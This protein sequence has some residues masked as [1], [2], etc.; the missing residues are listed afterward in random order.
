M[1]KSVKAVL[2]VM[3]GGALIGIGAAIGSA[4]QP[5]AKAASPV[6]AVTVTQSVPGPEV[7]VTE[8]VAPAPPPA[9]SVIGTFRGSGNQVTRAFNVPDSGDYIVTWTYSGNA[10]DSLGSSSPSNFIVTETGDGVGLG[11]PNAIGI[12]GSGS[13]EVTG[14][15]GTD[16]LNVQAAGQWVIT[17]KSA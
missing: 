1:R 11:L 2:G 12:S 14:A 6:P 15:D 9:G 3:A 10:D 5:A 13:T 7:T 4:G 17:V 8:T 16:S